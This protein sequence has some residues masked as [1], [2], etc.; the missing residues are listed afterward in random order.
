MSSKHLN[1]LLADD[2]MD[3]CFFFKEALEGL[4]LST[5]MTAV[6][7]GEQLM[8]LLTEEAYELPHVLFIDLNMPRK[9]GFECLAEIRLNQKL[10][11]VP[12]IVYSTSY[13]HDA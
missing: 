11:Q 1:L 5:N 13:Q 4:A 7:D 9:N 3:D 6:H 2:D 12:V 10:R 8:Q